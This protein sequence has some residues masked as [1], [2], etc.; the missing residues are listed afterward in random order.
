VDHTKDARNGRS[1]R[2][3]AVHLVMNQVQFDRPSVW[4]DVLVGA[5]TLTVYLATEVEKPT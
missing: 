5:P 3:Y 2:L 4:L 1:S